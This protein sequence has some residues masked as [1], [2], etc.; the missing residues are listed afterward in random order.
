M[1]VR[2]L[3]AELA[4]LNQ[5]GHG[6]REV[7]TSVLLERPHLGPMRVVGDC[8]VAFHYL[9]LG[10]VIVGGREE[11]IPDLERQQVQGRLT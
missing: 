5:D 10:K 1:K 2:E 8:C 11:P 4:R 6:D 9:P 7:M 3:L